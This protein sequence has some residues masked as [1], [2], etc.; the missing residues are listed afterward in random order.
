[1]SDNKTNILAGIL[2]QVALC[3][4]KNSADSRC[5]YIYHQ[6]KEPEGLE[7]FIKKDSREKL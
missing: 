3:S 4:L 6:E 1:M 5:M 2:K 7:D